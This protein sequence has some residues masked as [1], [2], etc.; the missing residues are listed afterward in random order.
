MDQSQPIPLSVEQ[1]KDLLKI[2]GK[3]LCVRADLISTRLLSKEDKQD[4]MSGEISIETLMTHVKV[5]MSNGMPDYANGKTDPYKEPELK[6]KPKYWD[7]IKKA[8]VRRFKR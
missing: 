3:M 7:D 5:W 4:L 2:V 6:P 1:C 8:P